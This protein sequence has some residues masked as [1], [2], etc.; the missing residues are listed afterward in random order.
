[1]YD[2]GTALLKNSSIDTPVCFKRGFY[3]MDG[4]QTT[5]EAEVQVNVHQ[6]WVVHNCVSLYTIARGTSAAT[7]PATMDLV[8]RN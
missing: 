7:C 8:K 3:K 4:R 6:V 2:V 1:M 5:T